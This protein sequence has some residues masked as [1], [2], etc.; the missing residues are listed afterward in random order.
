[1]KKK[2]FKISFGRIIGIFLLVAVAACFFLPM[3]SIFR[4]AFMDSNSVITIPVKCWQDNMLWENFSTV[5]RRLKLTVYIRNTVFTSIVPVVGVLFSAPLIAYSL[6]KIPWRG[7]Q[8]IF[9][10]ILF[11]MMIPWQVTQIPMYSIWA[12]LGLTD[13]YVPLLLPCFFGSAYYIYLV[14]QYM[15]S[16][17]NSIMEA[18]RIDGA[19]EFRI[20][21][22]VVYPMCQPVLA[23][24]PVMGFIAHWNDLNGPL[25]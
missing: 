5:F 2:K 18:A 21:Y 6:T 22:T 12:K 11:T 20:L 19:N 1:M 16:L 15:K 14:R 25:L 13:S 3:F 24:I 9:P 10:I 23:T 4:T 8:Y 7:G 17:P